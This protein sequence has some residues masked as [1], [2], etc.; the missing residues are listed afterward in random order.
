[1]DPLVTSITHKEDSWWSHTEEVDH[2]CYKLKYAPEQIIASLFKQTKPIVLLNEQ[3]WF[4]PM[5]LAEVLCSSFHICDIVLVVSMHDWLR[6][7][8]HHFKVIL[9]SA[10]QMWC[11]IQ[12]QITMCSR[13]LLYKYKYKIFIYTNT[14]TCV[15]TYLLIIFSYSTSPGTISSATN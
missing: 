2:P 11:F 1:M 10:P 4:R 3:K 9:I 14:N 13:L 15:A 5:H 12:L 8:C 6:E 7:W